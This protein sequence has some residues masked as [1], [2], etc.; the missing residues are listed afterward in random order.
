[1]TASVEGEQTRWYESRA[2]Y[3]A[4]GILASVVLV[5]S[6][7]N[8]VLVKDSDFNNHYILGKGFMQG[9][10]YLVPDRDPFCAHYPVGRLMLD[11]VFA[12]PPYRISRGINWIV[13]ILG[14]LFSLRLWNQMAQAGRPA[15]RPVAFA[16]GVLSLAVVLRWLVRD[17]D[18]CG[19]QLLLLLVL[20]ASAWAV[21]R[22]RSVLAGGLLG[23]AATYKATPLLFLPLL[24]YKRRWKPAIWMIVAVVL[25]NTVGPALFV[26]W[27]KMRDSSRMFWSKTKDVAQAT[28]QDPTANGVEPPRHTNRNL[29]LAVA[30]YLMT[31]GPE[32]PLFIAHREDRL[33]D[34]QPAEGA[35][36]HPL[37]MQFLDLS[38]KT[39]NL[40]IM[41][42]FAALAAVLVVRFRRPWGR[43]DSEGELAPE[44]AAVMALC[45]IMSPL[46]WGQHMVLLIPAVFLVVR[47]HL[48][49]PAS[50]WRTITLWLLPVLIL[51]PQREIIG[52]DLWLI[53]QSYKLDTIAAL[54]CLLLVLTIPKRA[55]EERGRDVCS[56]K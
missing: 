46:C 43:R 10:P 12:A 20:T 35:R 36:P 56:A 47:E 52:R 38:P 31:F 19:Q 24:L 14:L 42:V 45:A 3:I 48:A 54:L 25:L 28:R 41:G 37:F 34:G 40:V 55:S 13:G 39:A 23:L 26:G 44:W 50:R 27:A 22:R 4:A 11:M 8:G 7:I 53:L 21:T 33:Q 30:R 16:A 17:L 2:F 6:F 49:T 15:S 1:M 5:A 18:D 9:K 32:H 29:R 51:A